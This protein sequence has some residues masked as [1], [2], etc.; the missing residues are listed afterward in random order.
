MQGTGRA[1]RRFSG[2]GVKGVVIALLAAG[3]DVNLTDSW[4]RTPL[5]LYS[6]YG[7]DALDIILATG[8]DVNARDFRGR[9]P[10]HEAAEYENA[11]L[12]AALVAAGANVN[13]KDHMGNTPLH[14]AWHNHNSVVS[15]LLEL[16]A[17]PMA[18]NDRSMTSEPRNCENW[19]SRLF[20]EYIDFERL[21]ECIASGM[22]INARNP[23]G[24]FPLD[25]VIGEGSR[26]AHHDALVL[27]LDA[28]ANPNERDKRK[29][30]PLHRLANWGD[31]TTAVMLL[32]AGADIEA[33]DERGATPLHRATTNDERE[34]AS[35]LL[36]HGAELEARDRDGDT[37]LH[38]AL[39]SGRDATVK[40]LMD[41]GADVNAL[42]ASNQTPLH[43]AMRSSWRSSA[44]ERV[45]W[46]LERGADPNARRT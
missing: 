18:H 37:P 23:D 34:Y 11:S 22:D 35:V 41:A 36:E 42:N 12:I 16:G 14:I 7:T 17:D 46:L 29:M 13:A 20:R 1:R 21:R 44:K 30:T 5:H 19:Y 10:L 2:C 40:F 32:E 25:L 4:G 26:P 8:A 31:A 39:R 6:V 3:A 24:V 15:M 43:A 33:K 38:W 45:A 27:L 9:T 28:G